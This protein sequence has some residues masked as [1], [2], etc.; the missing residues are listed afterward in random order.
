MVIMDFSK[1][2]NVYGFFKVFQQVNHVNW[3]FGNLAT[4]SIIPLALSS[5][6][7]SLNFLVGNS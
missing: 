3:G 2:T 5:V 1:I 7:G 4:S 6:M